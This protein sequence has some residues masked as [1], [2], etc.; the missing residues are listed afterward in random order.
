M[1]S[2]LKSFAF[3]GIGLGVIAAAVSIIGFL[4]GRGSQPIALLL[5]AGFCLI[6]SG[7][8]IYCFASMLE[9]L[10]SIRRLLEKQRSS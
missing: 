10:T 3:L 7:A 1:V 6:L 2:L 4:A 9:E 8:V 5:G